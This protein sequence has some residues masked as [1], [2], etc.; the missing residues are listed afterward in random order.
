MSTHKQS[1]LERIIERVSRGSVPVDGGYWVESK[2]RRLT[3]A[4]THERGRI[5]ALGSQPL[6]R[7]RCAY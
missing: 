7:Q 1:L 3:S 5:P 4:A 6:S 2:G